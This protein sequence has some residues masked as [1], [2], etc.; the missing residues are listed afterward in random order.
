MNQI[1]IAGE[2]I[3]PL[4]LAA[5]YLRRAHTLAGQGRPV[6]RWKQACFA[7]GLII[8][9]G[10]T[11]SP[12]ESRGEELVSVHMVQ[13][14]LLA[15]LASLLFVLS[16]TGP[17]LA[18]LLMNRY[19]RPLRKLTHPVAA[20]SIFT[21][22]L[23]LWHSPPLYQ[24]VMGS[25][26]LHLIEHSSFVMTG[27]LLWMPLFGPLPKPQWFG[28]SAHLIYTVGIWL[29]GM[30]LANTLMWSG[31]T[32]YPDY[33]AGA[34]SHGVEPLTD[35][36]TAGA[37]LMLECMVAALAILAWVFLHWARADTEQQELLDLA[38]SLDVDL[39]DAR[40]TRAVNAGDGER[41]RRKLRE[42]SDAGNGR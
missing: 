28:R 5:A 7:A 23:F 38:H 10:A 39:T 15:D 9:G 31:T 13:H 32:F 14:L 37:L 20:I 2:I 18:P 27:I 16:F 4:G 29:P 33:A 21:A 19:L 8:V 17:L 30:A 12:V 22:N 41:L 25:N 40:A 34:L 42:A 35:Q 24:A 3:L 1:W 11:S 26:L 36:G 6:P